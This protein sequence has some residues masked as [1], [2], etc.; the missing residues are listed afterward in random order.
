MTNKKNETKID[1]EY[2]T[3]YLVEIDGE[4]LY[5]TVD[6]AL[7]VALASTQILRRGSK[8]WY[9]D[10]RPKWTIPDWLIASAWCKG[11]FDEH[12]DGNHHRRDRRGGAHRDVAAQYMDWPPEAFARVNAVRANARGQILLTNPAVAE[13]VAELVAELISHMRANLVH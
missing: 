5:F 4:E 1:V 7:A 13:A 11:V 3:F 10:D 12:R 2:L 8:G 9:P 6:E